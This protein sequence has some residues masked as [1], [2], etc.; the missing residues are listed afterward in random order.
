LSNPIRG[1]VDPLEMLPIAFKVKDKFW[2]EPPYPTLTGIGVTWLYGFDFE[3]KVIPRLPE[4]PER[5]LGPGVEPHPCAAS[6][7]AGL[8]APRERAVQRFQPVRLLLF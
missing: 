1:V 6:K 4:Q 5:T 3:Q 2:G 8:M 7:T